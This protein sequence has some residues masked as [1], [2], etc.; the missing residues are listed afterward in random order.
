MTMSKETINQSATNQIMSLEEMLINDNR[1]LREAGCELA[2]AAMQ[3]AKTYDGVHRLMLASSKWAMALANEGERRRL[4]SQNC[5]YSHP[6]SEEMTKKCAKQP[7]VSTSSEF[8][9]TNS[10]IVERLR[11]LSKA[12][13]EG[14]K[15]NMQVPDGPDRDADIILEAAADRIEALEAAQNS[16]KNE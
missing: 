16:Q 11:T 6:D 10:R 7:T 4:Y 13:T 9:L 5:G 15:F 14:R 2:E 12:V 3:V 1:H 8:A